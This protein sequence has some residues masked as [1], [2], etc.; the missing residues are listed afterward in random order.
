MITYNRFWGMTKERGVSTYWLRKNGIG[1]PIITKLQTGGN[2]DTVTINKLCT[3]LDCQPGDLM[4]YK[5]DG[6]A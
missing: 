4:E 1:A 5:K 2:I 3:L 6:E